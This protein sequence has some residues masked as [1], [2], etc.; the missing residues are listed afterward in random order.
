MRS[1]IYVISAMVAALSF[2]FSSSAVAQ[3]G[4]FN[5][6]G[7]T[8]GHVHYLVSDIEA[9]KKLWVD[10][11]GAEIGH[12]GP[13]ELIKV[14]GV[15]ILLMKQ[16]APE[17]PGEPTADHMALLV[18][19]LPAVRHKLEAAKIPV[20][21]K[22]VATFPDG[23]R[24]ELI[25]DHSLAVPV[26]FHHFHIFSADAEIAKWY[27]RHFGITFPA[28]PSFPGGRICFSTQSS[29]SRVATKGHVFDHIS[30]E[31]KD[32]L[33]FCKKLEA[34]GVKLDMKIIDAPAIG[35]KVTFVTDPIGTRIELTQG[36]AGK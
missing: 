6:K 32:L 9:H 22:S 5:D 18:R 11:F 34:D 29:P 25:E 23:V 24:L 30:F 35:L 19:N 12:A 1:M 7:V 10:I 2:I 17:S 4:P 36:F 3:L 27:E 14:P 13:I 15:I 21:D 31:I 20:S 33:E 26:A 16:S 28:A 8:I